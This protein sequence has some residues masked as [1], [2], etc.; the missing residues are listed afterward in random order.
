MS[1]LNVELFRG[2]A[3]AVVSFSVVVSSVVTQTGRRE[4][5]FRIANVFVSI[6]YFVTENTLKLFAF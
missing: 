2:D 1:K 5:L 3:D 4:I 6:H